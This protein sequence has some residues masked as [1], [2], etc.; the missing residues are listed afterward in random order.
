MRRR[1]DRFASFNNLSSLMRILIVEDDIGIAKAVRRGLVRMHYSV[2]LA[3]D[4]EEGRELVFVNQY[5]LI[6][7]D[8]RLPKMDGKALCRALRDADITT[9]ILMLT[10]VGSSD[11]IIDCLDEGADDYMTKPFDFG[12]LLARVRSLIRRGNDAKRAEIQVGDLVL[13]T[14]TRSVLVGG[15]P[16]E[17]TA[18]EFALLEYFVLNKGKVLTREQISEHVWDINFDPKSNVIESLVRLVRQKID[19]DAESPMIK[20]VRGVGYRFVEP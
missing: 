20:T 10:A 9:P 17:M 7:L 13:H 8:I 16:V 5:D 4:G 15:K 14:G 19:H 6:I 2:D 1:A 11:A 18:K 3:H 12:V